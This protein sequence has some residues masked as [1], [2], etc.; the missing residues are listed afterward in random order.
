MP[1]QIESVDLLGGHPDFRS[2][3]ES[4]LAVILRGTVKIQASLKMELK[5]LLCKALLNMHRI[6]WLQCF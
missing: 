2:H 6:R 4:K 5:I 1:W 3:S